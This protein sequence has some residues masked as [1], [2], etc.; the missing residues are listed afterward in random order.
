[1]DA[2]LRVDGPPSCARRIS[3]EGGLVVYK[4]AVA[5]FQVPPDVAKGLQTPGKEFVLMRGERMSYD[6]ENRA[7]YLEQ[8]ILGQE[9][10]LG[11]KSSPVFKARG[12]L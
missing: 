11:L 6:L 5:P 9:M 12:F 7:R 1:M 10:C 4:V 8:C 2:L 3:T